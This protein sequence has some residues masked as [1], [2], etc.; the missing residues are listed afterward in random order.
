VR[1]EGQQELTAKASGIVSDVVVQPGQRV[2]QGDVLVRFYLAQEQSELDR[3]Q[4]ELDTQ[5]VQVMRIPGDQTARQAAATLQAQRDLAQRKLAERTLVAPQ[6]GLVSDIRV[7]PGQAANPG[8]PLVVLAAEQSRARI[9]AFVPAQY[10]PMLYPGQSLRL[11]LTGYR[12]MYRELTVTSVGDVA[13]GPGE[14][15][16]YLG[17]DLAD[18]VSIDGPVVLVHAELPSSTF[19][20]S[21][22]SYHFYNGMPARAD[23]RV[24]AE[25]IA[26]T[27]VP[28]LRFVFGMS[29]E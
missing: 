7:H 24:R 15:R 16:R 18:A 14:V 11:E 23:I 8:D 4:H 26:I 25:R 28:G 10:R 13:I 21:G 22:Q 19:E 17:P 3:L 27:L 20:A 12:Y 29:H 2:H 1:I 6:D 5:I 9:V